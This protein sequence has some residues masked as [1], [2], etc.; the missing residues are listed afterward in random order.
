MFIKDKIHAGCCG[1]ESH[2]ES[3]QQ[4]PSN[5]YTSSSFD[6]LKQD[7]GRLMHCRLFVVGGGGRS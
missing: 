3:Q 2:F 6:E 1:H 5:N 4:H 7:V